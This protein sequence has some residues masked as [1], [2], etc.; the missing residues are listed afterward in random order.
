MVNCPYGKCRMVNLCKGNHCVR[1][2]MEKDGWVLDKDG[3]FKEKAVEA[4]R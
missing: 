4:K 2:A 1:E 3:Q